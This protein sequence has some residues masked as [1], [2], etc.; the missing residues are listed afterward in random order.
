[1]THGITFDTSGN[2]VNSAIM[3]KPHVLMEK[4]VEKDHKRRDE[5]EKTKQTA[6]PLDKSRPISSTPISGTPWAVVWTGDKRV[7]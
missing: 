5:T 3:N 2:M 6:K 1:M 4:E 7:L